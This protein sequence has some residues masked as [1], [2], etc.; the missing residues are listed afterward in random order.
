MK[1]ILCRDLQAQKDS[2]EAKGKEESMQ[3][4]ICPASSIHWIELTLRD[5]QGHQYVIY[6]NLKCSS[7]THSFDYL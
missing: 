2:L 6:C 7:P 5:P 1:V 4:V 3:H